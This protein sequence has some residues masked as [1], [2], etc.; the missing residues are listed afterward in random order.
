MFSRNYCT[1]FH[2]E[3]FKHSS[4]VPNMF[5]NCLVLSEVWDDTKILLVVVIV[6][7]WAACRLFVSILFDNFELLGIIWFTRFL[8][9]VCEN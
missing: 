8:F 4:S 2:F 3:R 1:S 7:K 5:Q 6:S 9:F